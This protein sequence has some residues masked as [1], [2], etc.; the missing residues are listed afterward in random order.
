[1]K[2]VLKLGLAVLAAATLA[3]CGSGDSS[4]AADKYVGNWKSSCYK[5]TSTNG[6]IYYYINKAN[7]A[8]VSAAEITITATYDAHSDAACANKLGS[9]N[10]TAR[11]MNIGAET[12]F[13]GAKSDAI[14]LTNI[15]TGEAFP[16]FATADATRLNIVSYTPGTIPT[17]WGSASPYTKQ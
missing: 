16:G 7:Y 3:A 4:E 10:L 15:S 5:D 17:G 8:K 2:N 13:L 1:M 9:G 12:T 11:K 14:V 6:N